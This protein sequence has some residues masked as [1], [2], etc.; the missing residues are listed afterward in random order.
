MNHYQDI[1]NA[2]EK[3]LLPV[4]KRFAPVLIKG[5]GCYAQDAEGKSYLD[6]TSGIGVNSLG[7][8]DD[9]WVLA[10]SNQ[11]ATLQHT[12]NLFHTLPGAQLAQQLCA[13]TN[14]DK[15]FF[16]N[17][18]AEA[19][20]GSLKAARK[21][22]FLKYG[23]GRHTIISLSNSFHGRT[24]ATLTATGQ[25]SFHHF[26]NPFLPGIKTVEAGDFSA[27]EAA[28]T[29]DVCAVIFEPIQGEGG[30]CPLP[31]DYLQNMQTLCNQKDILLI[32][33]EVQCGVG[34]TGTFLGCEA[35]GVK[36]DIVSLA[37]GLGGGLPIG[38][39]LLATTCSH[40]LTAGDH[41]STFGANPVVCAGALAVLHRLTPAFLSQIAENG[42][43]LIQGLQQLP[44]VQA[45][46]GRGLMLG[47][48]FAPGI[49][50]TDVRTAAEEKGLLCLLA[51]D[52]LRLL[53]PLVVTPAEIAEGLSVLNSVMQTFAFA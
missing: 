5:K 4:Y 10:V 35:S 21:Y 29:Q 8:C 40:V 32:A 38:A 1:L 16:C 18:G 31:N 48:S 2:G 41:G 53:P 9:E 50:A 22:S 42:N 44:G 34:R 46:T 49:N 47:I 13:K 20:E 36:P 15:V 24:M 25:D 6:F 19:N 28:L 43:M 27:L 39:T 37:K 11:A 7:W 23:E 14:M 51:K 45:V 52:K 12:S 17:S 30:V 26:F 33:D 3:S